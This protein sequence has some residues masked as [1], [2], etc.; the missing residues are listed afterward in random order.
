M[1]RCPVCLHFFPSLLYCA[2][3]LQVAIKTVR[4]RLLLMSG[5][6]HVPHLHRNIHRILGL[7]R[8]RPGQLSTIVVDEGLFYLS[9]VVVVSA[10]PG[11]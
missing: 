5:Y 8:W 11:H 4:E 7:I 9:R 6:V 3:N 1:A 10:M 2:E